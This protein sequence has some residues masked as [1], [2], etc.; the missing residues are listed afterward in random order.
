MAEKIL[1]S[2]TE[3]TK[4]EMVP[5]QRPLMPVHIFNAAIKGDTDYLVRCLGL[6]EREEV[7][8]TVRASQSTPQQIEEEHETVQFG[9]GSATR[10]GDTLL[11]LLITKRHNKLALK[12]FTKDMSLLKARNRKQETPLHDA[13]KVGNEEVIRDL[14][15][16]SPTVVKDALGKT[17]ENKDTALHVAANHNHK[18][19]VSELMKLDPQAAY[20]E[21][22]QGFSPL[23]IATVEGH[24]SVVEVMLQVDTTLACTQFSDG[25]FPVHVVAR[26]GNAILVEHF[27]REYPDYAKLID[28]CGRNL[29]HMVAEHNHSKMLTTG[30]ALTNQFNKMVENMIN[31][32]DYEG[33]TPLHMAAMKGH[34][35]VMRTIWD[36]LNHDKAALVQNQKGKTA[37]DLSRDQLLDTK[38]E[39]ETVPD[40]LLAM[41]ANL[42]MAAVKGDSNVLIRRLGLP[43]DT[44]NEIQVTIEDSG[45]NFQQTEAEHHV[46]ECE[47]GSTATGF[48]DTLL[49][50]L[51]TEGH[52]ELAMKVFTKDMSLLKAHNRKLETPLHDA[53]KVGNEEVIR[54]LIQLSTNDVKDALRETNENGDTAL[55]VAVNHNHKGIVSELMKLDPQVA[56]EEN[57]QGFS[58][59]YIATVEGHTSLVKAMLQVDIIL[60]CTRFSDGTFP[61]HVAA[62]MGNEDLVEHFLREYPDYA[63]LLDSCGRNLFH[64]AAEH[65]NSDVF[66]EVFALT[67]D[68][69]PQISQMVES[70]INARD[71]EGNTP[72]HLAAMKGH[73]SI[74]AAILDKLNYD[75]AALVPNRKGKTAFRLSYDQLLDTK[76]VNRVK[77][78]IYVKQEGWYFRRKWFRIVKFRISNQLERVQ[79]IGLGC[80]LITTV[81]FA[82]AFTV[83]GGYNADNGA[84]V[85]G[86]RFMFRAF[87]LA[88]TLAFIQAFQ[89]LFA[90][91]S[92]SLANPGYID[93]EYAFY[94]FLS[95]ASC[96]VIAFGLSSY[97]MLAPVSL[98]IAIIVL[99]VS[100]LVGSPTVF[101]VYRME[102]DFCR[103][104]DN[105]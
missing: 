77:L 83:P 74:M 60:A 86:K 62:R 24:T 20:E 5:Q 69:N 91:V 81:A 4:S 92:Q 19:V 16:L 40:S 63:K 73:K 89:S 55:H 94:K 23:Y 46:A 61:V 87:I 72:L 75:Q 76:Q 17:N 67:K 6:E 51:I 49:H 26:M 104:W 68:D 97:V 7:K 58:P 37:F 95:A 82:A 41:D 22:K 71:Y 14:I 31:A 33:N 98:P 43:T 11:H 59:L 42:F 105:L 15:R 57:K 100:L 21:N 101:I 90:V 50:L 2:H 103:D 54:N 84:P 80:V 36:K 102:K 48:G 12:V 45:S 35:F 53:A 25:T 52:N 18:G 29:F 1:S 93:L 99:V 65:D 66:T 28:S 96:M 30:F 34:K 27:F 8:V 10:F 38:E 64:M 79:I 32:K 85:L 47:L 70:M 78:D 39:K 88:N 44:Q 3:A 56:Y 13:A 9:L